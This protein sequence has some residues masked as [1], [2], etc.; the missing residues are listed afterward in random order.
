M[1]EKGS[2]AAKII[3]ELSGTSDRTAQAFMKI[4]DQI[5]KTNASVVKIQEVVDLIAEI[6]SQTNLLSLNASIEAARA[7]EAGKGF[8]V[9]ASE[10]QK[11]AEQTNSSAGNINEIILSLSEESR[12][13]VQSISE[14]TEM[15]MDQ[16]QKLAETKDRFYT[17][18]GGI[19]SVGSG[20]KG[21]LE[22][23]ETCG[24][25]GAH[26]VD[27]MT[28]LSAIAQENTATTQQTN[29]SMEELKDATVSLLKTASEL[30]ELSKAVKEDLSYFT[31]ED[32]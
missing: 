3:Q 24:R 16:K 10:I 28:S 31:T 17:V 8:A 15:I 23:A 13:T 29:D 12:Q 6:A 27:I 18:E 1:K 11:L 9:V 5:H 26:V 4:S 30:K 32:S 19:L 21:V 14:V 22:Q 2:Q 20:M 25:A 7:G